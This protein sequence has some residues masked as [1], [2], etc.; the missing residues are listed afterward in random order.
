MFTQGARS[1]R[2]RNMATSIYK[3]DT[4][5]GEFARLYEAKLASLALEYS[6]TYVETSW[7]R[8]HVLVAGDEGLPPVVLLHGVNACAPIAL[9]PIQGLAG[10][11][12]IYAIDI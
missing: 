3:S 9:E 1:S 11:Y 10:R 8:T 7:G 4:F 12:R 5:Q 2:R 6:D